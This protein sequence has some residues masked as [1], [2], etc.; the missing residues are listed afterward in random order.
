MTNRSIQYPV[1]RLHIPVGEFFSHFVNILYIKFTKISNF[2]SSLR[3]RTE[4]RTGLSRFPL[5]VGIVNHK[6]VGYFCGRPTLPPG[7][8]L[9]PEAGLLSSSEFGH[10]TPVVTPS[11]R[12]FR[13]RTR[14]GLRCFPPI[15]QE[16]R[17]ISLLSVLSANLRTF[18]RLIYIPVNEARNRDRVRFVDQ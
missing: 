2:G 16:S 7:T 18:A 1:L 13:F 3:I 6:S 11:I 12:L 17:R 8:S 5:P 4:T 14:R 10:Q 15:A 9:I